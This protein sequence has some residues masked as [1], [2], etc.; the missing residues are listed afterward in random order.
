VIVDAEDRIYPFTDRAED[1]T[2]N[3]RWGVYRVKYL[4][5]HGFL[6]LER[7]RQLAYHHPETGEWDALESSSVRITFTELFGV[8]RNHN[9]DPLARPRREAYEAYVP[10][11]HRANYLSLSRLPLEDILAIEEDGDLVHEVPVLYVRGHSSLLLVENPTHWALER[12]RA[13]GG[14]QA[15]KVHPEKR[16]AFFKDFPALQ[17]DEPAPI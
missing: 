10:E 12:R 17:P 6:V 3:P 8:P 4:H 9:I 5:P 7:R 16:V 11:A 15:I 2:T 13:Y 14:P 1:F